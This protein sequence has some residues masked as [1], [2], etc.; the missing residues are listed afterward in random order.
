MQ[1]PK[2]SDGR[3]ETPRE[4]V[5]PLLER[6]LRPAAFPSA[7]PS[8]FPGALPCAPSAGNLVGYSRRHGG[9]GHHFAVSA[10]G[11]DGRGQGPKTRIQEA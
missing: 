8:A 2:L 10:P 6:T 9:S 5:S 3:V 4:T 1:S 11:P 7:F